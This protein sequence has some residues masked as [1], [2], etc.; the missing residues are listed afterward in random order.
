M[1][2][3][4]VAQIVLAPAAG[5]LA[6][7]GREALDIPCPFGMACSKGLACLFEPISLGFQFVNLA[8]GARLPAIEAARVEEERP[9]HLPP[10]VLTTLIL[11]YPIRPTRNRNSR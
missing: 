7:A 10:G 4:P 6:F 2:E 3:R 9:S 8:A 11:T 5:D 1:G